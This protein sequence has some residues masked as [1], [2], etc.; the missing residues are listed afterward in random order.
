MENMEKRGSNID[1]MID[2]IVDDHQIIIPVSCK[3]FI[4]KMIKIDL[5]VNM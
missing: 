5:L 3:I 4:S 2:R 1:I